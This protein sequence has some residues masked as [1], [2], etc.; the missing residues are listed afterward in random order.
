MSWLP[1]SWGPNSNRLTLSPLALHE[2][3]LALKRQGSVLKNFFM[4]T[5]QKIKR[6]GGNPHNRDICTEEASSN[7]EAYKKWRHIRMQHNYIVP[8]SSSLSTTCPHLNSLIRRSH[9]NIRTGPSFSSDRHHPE[10]ERW[11]EGKF[12]MVDAASEVG[13]VPHGHSEPGKLPAMAEE[14][15]IVSLNHLGLTGEQRKV[16]VEDNGLRERIPKSIRRRVD[17]R[18]HRCTTTPWAESCSSRTELLQPWDIGSLRRHLQQRMKYRTCVFENDFHE[19][20]S[21]QRSLMEE[22]LV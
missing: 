7:M 4:K 19:L 14:E 3:D 21:F 6:N 17:I 15:S 13:V 8:S 1:A 9:I 22:K 2:S 11:R 5:C 10:E 20:L 16:V 18:R 12:P